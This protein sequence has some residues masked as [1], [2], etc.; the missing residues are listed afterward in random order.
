MITATLAGLFLSSLLDQHLNEVAAR[1][2]GKDGN[3]RQRKIL[4][5]VILSLFSVAW[6][7][8]YY[9]DYVEGLNTNSKLAF[10][11]NGWEPIRNWIESN[12]NEN[13]VYLSS[14]SARLWAWYLNKVVVGLTVFEDGVSLPN[15]NI[16]FNHLVVLIQTYNVSFIIV[17]R[18]YQSY[19]SYFPKMV[20][21][22]GA[23][24]VGLTISINTSF[25]NYN[26][27][28]VASSDSSVTPLG[29]YLIDVQYVGS[30]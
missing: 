23:I 6:A 9:I 26:L 25:G 11:S 16:T 1:I 27:T 29:V 13:D 12:S 2:L 21:L 17:D 22:M 30:S 7:S 5:V 10:S 20:Q 15:E 8:P 28:N 18:S 4:V 3:S 14:A 24:T 19:G